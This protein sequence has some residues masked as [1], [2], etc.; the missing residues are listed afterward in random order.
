L[1]ARDSTGTCRFPAASPY[2]PLAHPI[3][4]TRT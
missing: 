2:I 4:G 1:K 3:G